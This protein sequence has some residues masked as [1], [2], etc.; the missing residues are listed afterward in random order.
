MKIVTA[1]IKDI[2]YFISENTT[3]HTNWLKTLVNEWQVFYKNRYL[4][5]R[6]DKQ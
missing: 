5:I 2:N 6:F 1:E 3:I 4:K